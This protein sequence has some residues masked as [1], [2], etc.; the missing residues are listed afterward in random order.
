MG[1]TDSDT[2]QWWLEHGF[3]GIGSGVLGGL[4][5]G[6]AV[7]AAIWW[8][9][10]VRTQQR[11]EDADRELRHAVRDVL[12]ALE[13]I[14]AVIPG[15]RKYTDEERRAFK[16]AYNRLATRSIYA[17][18]FA[19]PRKADTLVRDLVWFVDQDVSPAQME[20]GGRA[21]KAARNTLEARLLGWLQDPAA[22]EEEVDPIETS[23]A[24]ALAETSISPPASD[25]SGDQGDRRP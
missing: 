7:A 21:F 19:G 11:E 14:R 4:A 16:V 24:K 9:S 3:D 10:R 1:W 6:G 20:S 23:Y 12:L 22:Y 17:Q 2:W 8:E 13:E 5:T 25:D 18:V 15:A